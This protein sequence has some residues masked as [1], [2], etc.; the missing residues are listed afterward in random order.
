M[1]AASSVARRRRVAV[2]VTT[3]FAGCAAPP[4]PRF[5]PGGP[6]AAF[7]GAE[8]GYPASVIY[9][10]RNFVGAFSHHDRIWEHRTV[11]RAVAPRPLQRAAAE[12]AVRYRH[13]GRER[14]LDDYLEH[15]PAT[16]LLVM[17]GDSILVERYRYGRHDRHRL[18]S[19]SM[20]KTVTAMLVGVALAE[21]RLRSLDDPAG[22][23][24][25]ELAGSAYGKTSIRHLLQMSSGVRFRES[26][27][28]PDIGRLWL[29][30]VGHMGPGGAHALR[31][32]DERARQPGAL[33][34]YASAETQLLGLVV[35]RAVAR[36]LAEYLQQKIWQPMGAEADASWLVD[37][38]GQ[39][40]AYCCLNAVLR[41]YARLALLLADD[42][43]RDGREI[44][45]AAWVREATTVPEDRPDLHG[46]WPDTGFGYGYQTWVFPGPRRMFALIGVHGQA[47]YVDPASRL[48]LVH[49]AVR[50]VL[51]DPNRE[52]LALWQALVAQ[53][54]K[55]A[56]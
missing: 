49:T 13:G 7:Y 42:G 2:V 32:F 4:S 27:G 21:G 36:P 33:F 39:E 24:V 56:R 50:P 45:P 6:D 3:A 10:P 53:L 8:R 28:G 31:P 16:G 47:I 1:H 20:A 5:D 14:T 52:T 22:A 9:H 37:A 11:L 54:G 34:A 30:T 43:R 44:I 17:Q 38:A 26:G 40:A 51:E 15:N 48:V 23:Y 35:S 46:V 12:P 29:D 19:F 55:P 18:A 25:P 41:D